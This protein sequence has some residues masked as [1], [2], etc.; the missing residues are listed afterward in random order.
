MA[1]LVDSSVV[2]EMERR[3]RSLGALRRIVPGEPL[4]LAAITAS[5]L[6]VGVHRAA[7]PERRSRRLDFIEAV[8]GEV[9]IIPF[10]LPIARVHARVLAELTATGQM[11]D[12]NDLLIAATALAHGYDVLTHNLRHFER[13]PRLVV[14]RP[15]W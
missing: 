9:P 3:D 5:E 13:V 1:R 12:A 7:S 4:A 6:L 15:S 10:D 2:I 11:I 8:L 14:H